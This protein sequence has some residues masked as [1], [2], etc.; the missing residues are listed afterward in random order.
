[1][2]FKIFVSKK[3]QNQHKFN[4]PVVPHLNPLLYTI[5]VV[6]GFSGKTEMHPFNN[7]CQKKPRNSENPRSSGECHLWR[8]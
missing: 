7:Q 2:S 8:F 4:I 1:M 3:E 5:L 6:L